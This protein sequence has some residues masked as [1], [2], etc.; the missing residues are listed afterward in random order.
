MQCFTGQMQRK[1]PHRHEYESGENCRA[2]WE[3]P[4]DKE[5]RLAMLC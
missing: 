4:R 1:P 5:P 3:R 2:H